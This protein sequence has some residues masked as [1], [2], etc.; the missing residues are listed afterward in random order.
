MSLDDATVRKI[1]TLARIDLADADLAPLA[2]E[3][4]GIMSWIEQ[5]QEVDTDAV[6]PMSGG[7]DMTLSWRKDAVSDGGHADK[8]LANAPEAHEGFFGVPKVVE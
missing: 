4:S 3:L 6:E 2:K 7:T 1:A 8:V 5:L